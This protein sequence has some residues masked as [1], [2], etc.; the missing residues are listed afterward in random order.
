M[1]RATSIRLTPADRGC[2]FNPRRCGIVFGWLLFF[3]PPFVVALTA[4]ETSPPAAETIPTVAKLEPAEALRGAQVCI[5]RTNFPASAADFKITVG[6]S[7]AFA[8]TA[9]AGDR[10][11]IMFNLPKDAPLGRQTARVCITVDDAK[12]GP[13]PAPVPGHNYDFTV[14]REPSDPLALTAIDPPV[15]Y[16]HQGSIDLRLIGS[17]F[18]NIPP[19]R[20]IARS[21]LRHPVPCRRT[22]RRSRADDLR[23]SSPADGRCA[24]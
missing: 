22:K 5:F 2:R 8:P 19:R 4:Q 11:Y 24:I 21:E 23:L 16:V 6:N 13:L 1:F 18:S 9:V 17:G 14:L 7:A 10:S 15:V 20:S 3:G 12:T